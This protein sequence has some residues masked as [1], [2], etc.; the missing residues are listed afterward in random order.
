MAIE[1]MKQ[2]ASGGGPWLFSVNIF[3]PHHSFDPPLKYLQRYLDR[4]DEVPLPKYV[5]GELE[6]KPIWQQNDHKGPYGGIK[7]WGYENMTE[8]DHRMIRAAYW[9]MCDLIDAQVGRM[10]EALKESGQLDNTVVIFMSDHGEMLGD[11]GIYFKGPYF[12]E[13]AVHVPLIISWPGNIRGGRSSKALVELTDLA[14]TL[15]DITGI[16]HH[17]GMQ[18]KSLWPLL[19]GES[20]L[21][22]HRDNVYS[23]FYGANSNYRPGAYTTMV[24]TE[25]HKLTVAHGQNTGELYDLDADPTETSNLWDN[26]DYREVRH[27]LMMRMLDRMAWTVDPLP[28]REAP[29]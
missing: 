9:A 19:R 15:L 10:L 7:R 14:Q 3:D 8:R 29:W 26:P 2:Q 16:E 22:N 6:N 17:P 27:E 21:N 1:F 25:R 11:H 23:E 12:Y 18:G 13:P 24:R 20:D 4:L 28:E 5:E